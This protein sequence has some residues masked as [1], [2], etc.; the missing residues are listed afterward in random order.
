M[1]A[2]EEGSR[3]SE[4]SQTSEDTV[5][6]RRVSPFRPRAHSEVSSGESSRLI[7]ATDLITCYKCGKNMPKDEFALALIRNHCKPFTP[8]L[9]ADREKNEVDHNRIHAADVLHGC[10][11]LTVHP[12]S[13]FKN[14]KVSKKGDNSKKKSKKKNLPKDGQS[15]SNASCEKKK[16]AKSNESKKCCSGNAGTSG[17]KNEVKFHPNSKLPMITTMSNLEVMAFYTA[18]AM[19]DYDHPGKTNAF[20][21]ASDD[22]KAIMYNDRSVLENHHACEAWKLLCIEEHLFIDVL[23]ENE[24]RRF[25]YL[26]LEYILATDLKMHFDLVALF[27]DKIHDIDFYCEKDRLQMMQMLIKTADISSPMKPRALHMEWTNRICEEFYEQGDLEKALEMPVTQFMDRNE[28]NVE[29]LQASFI[30]HIVAPLAK[31]MDFACFLPI[32][33]GLQQSELIIN[34]NHNDTIWKNRIEE[35]KKVAKI[36]RGENPDLSSEDSDEEDDEDNEF[37]AP[38]YNNENSSGEIIEN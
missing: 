19:H 14:Q 37:E 10:Y 21:V 29:E 12:I 23:D 11:Y 22:Y 33:P 13:A 30:G 35:K 1:S 7:Q 26:V 4:D 25:R 8:L 2:F 6:K 20:L 27:K 32:L 24:F 34:L 15:S 17:V 31:I 16:K 38:E 9:Y 36:A 28:P 5:E 18:A 3:D